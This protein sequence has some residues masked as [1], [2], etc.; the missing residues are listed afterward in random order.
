MKHM[1]GTKDIAEDIVIYP[2]SQTQL[3]TTPFIQ[4]FGILNNELAKRDF[5]I[6]VGY[7][8]RDI[9]IRTMFEKALA[10]DNRRRVIL[11][12]PDASKKIKP[13]FNK[14]VLGQL[15]CLDVFFGRKQD[16]ELVNKKISETLSIEA[17][18]N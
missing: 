9:I 7:S 13:L 3:Y 1:S 17:N 11:V 18:A 6:V 15:I 10:A 4:L 5:W 14:T 8:F 16:Y 2:L 12:S